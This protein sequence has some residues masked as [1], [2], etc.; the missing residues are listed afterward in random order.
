MENKKETAPDVRDREQE[1][2]EVLEQYS[3]KRG[4]TIEDHISSY[5]KRDLEYVAEL[6]RRAGI[7][8]ASSE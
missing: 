8:A 4:E 5:E 7:A 3:A 2:K 1:F 6:R